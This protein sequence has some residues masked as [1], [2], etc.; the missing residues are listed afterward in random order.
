MQIGECVAIW[1]RPNF[2][3]IMYPYCPP[4]IT[5]PKVIYQE[6]NIWLSSLVLLVYAYK[7]VGN[8]C[9]SAKSFSSFIYLR[10]S[11]LQCPK[12]LNFLLFRCLNSTTMFRYNNVSIM[13]IIKII[14]LLLNFL[15]VH[16]HPLFQTI[17]QVYC[18]VF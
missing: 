13:W 11:T 15:N 17:N 7:H 16:K 4:H 5:K 10:G 6:S 9:R 3:T 14:G 1:W 2:E 18:W 8:P 12:T